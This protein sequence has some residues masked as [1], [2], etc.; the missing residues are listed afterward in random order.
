MQIRNLGKGYFTSFL[1]KHKNKFLHIKYEINRKFIALIVSFV[2]L[3]YDRLFNQNI[4]SHNRLK[5]ERLQRF[6]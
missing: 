4:I 2:K 5:F 3:K 1:I 6:F